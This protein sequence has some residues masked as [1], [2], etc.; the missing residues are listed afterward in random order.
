MHKKIIAATTANYLADEA[1]KFNEGIIEEGGQA[2]SDVKAL[3]NMHAS[4]LTGRV[5]LLENAL[6]T[7]E[8][9]SMK[10]T[11]KNYSQVLGGELGRRKEELEKTKRD[12]DKLEK[13]KEEIDE[14]KARFENEI[15]QH[16]QDREKLVEDLKKKEEQQKKNN[17]LYEEKIKNQKEI[18]EKRTRMDNELKGIKVQI[19]S[20]E[21]RLSNITDDTS[22]SERASLRNR[23]TELEATAVELEKKLADHDKELR[24]IN[25]EIEKVERDIRLIH[26]NIQ[27]IHINMGHHDSAIE[28][29]ERKL[30]ALQRRQ[31]ELGRENTDL[32]R[33]LGEMERPEYLGGWNQPGGSGG[34]PPGG[35][36][37]TPRQG[38]F[39]LDVNIGASVG[40]FNRESHKFY[41]PHDAEVFAK[42]VKSGT[43]SLRN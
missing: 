20:N 3:K 22:S 2:M 29:L 19:K 26:S 13:E 21:T 12:N 11:L 32:R 27:D 1:R 41:S 4:A 43:F 7:T 39:F 14:K 6:K 28:E 18:D 36:T 33:K 40:D 5:E 30:G 42:R 23:T 34:V 17:A 38:S 24:Q 25:R 37:P 9:K 35:V 16:K 8:D 31:D 15:G 10:E